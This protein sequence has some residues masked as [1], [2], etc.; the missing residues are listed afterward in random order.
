[1]FW[2]QGES[3]ICFWEVLR[4]FT[5]LT[6]TC[7]I[8]EHTKS[9]VMAVSGC[10]GPRCAIKVIL[11]LV[12]TH[13]WASTQKQITH[14]LC[15]C[16]RKCIKKVVGAHLLASL[17]RRACPW[18][19]TAALSRFWS[20]M[21]CMKREYKC[22]NLINIRVLYAYTHVCSYIHTYIQTYINCVYVTIE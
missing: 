3:M 1:M 10:N 12:N 16:M 9:S 15:A 19:L 18:I 4:S 2:V 13:E 14:I 11:S 8:C 5:L 21:I 7:H 17:C 20:W 6:Q 22:H